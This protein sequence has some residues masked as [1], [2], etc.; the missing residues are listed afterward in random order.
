MKIPLGVEGEILA[1]EKD[2]HLVVVRDD[3]ANTG[4]FLIYER[5]AGSHGP[6]AGGAFD[7]WVENEAQLEAFF[8]EASW[9]VS[10]RN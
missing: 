8:A 9:N 5:W 4:G 7:S 1:S 6:N 10:W 2:G 3:S